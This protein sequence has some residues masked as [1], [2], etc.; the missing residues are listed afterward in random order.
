MFPAFVELQE[1]LV[2]KMILSIIMGTLEIC[3]SNDTRDA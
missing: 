2:Q 1:S 3:W